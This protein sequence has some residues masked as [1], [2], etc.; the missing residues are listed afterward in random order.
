MINPDKEEDKKSVDCYDDSGGE[1]SE[2]FG[3]VLLVL[4]I[5]CIIVGF[6]YSG[7]KFCLYGV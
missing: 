3:I 7:I 1:Y 4:I 5:L 2:I 6:G